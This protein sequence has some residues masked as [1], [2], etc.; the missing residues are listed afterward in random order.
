M[1]GNLCKDFGVGDKQEAGL[2]C[3]SGEAPRPQEECEGNAY[4]SPYFP[5]FKG[6]ACGFGRT[7][8]LDL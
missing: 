7:F 5:G 2:P 6:W 4:V 8:N 3:G 1:R